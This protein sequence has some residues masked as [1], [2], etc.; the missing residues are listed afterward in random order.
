ML[1]PVC[2]QL[3]LPNFYDENPEPVTES[4]E[5][6]EP[7]REITEEQIAEKA[8]ASKKETFRNILILSGGFVFFVFSAGEFS[9]L[10]SMLISI[11]SKVL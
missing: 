11:P 2:L 6:E 5:V 8:K 1:I 3:N 7:L 9:N 4:P 10:F